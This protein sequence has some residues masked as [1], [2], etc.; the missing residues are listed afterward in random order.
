MRK[1]SRHVF[2]T[3]VPNRISNRHKEM[4]YMY[5]LFHMIDRSETKQTYPEPAELTIAAHYQSLF[6]KGPG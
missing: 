1:R 3:S 2:Q 4:H 6:K 5:I